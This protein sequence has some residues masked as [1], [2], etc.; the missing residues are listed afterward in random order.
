MADVLA[1]TATLAE[2]RADAFGLM[3]T[4][5]TLQRP[6]HQPLRQRLEKLAQETGGAVV[7]LNELDKLTDLIPNRARRTPDDIREPLWDSYLALIIVVSL[8]TIEWIGR[9]VIR[10][11]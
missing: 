5:P 7:P 1:E 9:K 10:L 6:E 3:E 8:A 4:D 2:A 11:V